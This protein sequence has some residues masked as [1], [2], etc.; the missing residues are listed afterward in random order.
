MA[1]HWLAGVHHDG[2]STYVS[3][4]YPHSGETVTITIRVPTSAPVS[5]V[6]CRVLEDGEFRHLDMQLRHTTG[7]VNLWSLD[8]L[9]QQPRVEYS[10]KLMTSE[11]AYYYS[12]MGLSRADHPTFFDF[13]ILADYDAPHWVRSAVFYQIFPDRFHNGDP[14]NDV[15][16]G[17]WEREGV[18]TRKL[19]WGELPIPWV[20]A[21]SVDFAGGDLQGIMQKLDYIASLGIGALYLTP[22]FT[23]ASNHHYDASTFNE[24]D[25]HLG[26][27][28][29][30]V[31]LRRALTERGM[32]LVLDITPNH[33]GVTHYWFT[34]A[35]A[36]PHGE[37][38]EYFVYNE[39]QK[40]FETWL[41]VSSLI[42]LNYNSQK[43]RDEMYR[44]PDSAIRRWLAAPYS[45]DGWRLDVANMVGNLRMS[46]LD[47]EVW[48][49]MRPYVKRDNP[50]AYLLGEYFQDGTP[51]TQGTELDAA[52]NY[53]GFNTPVRRWLGGADLGT[54]DDKVWGDTSLLP[55]DALAL[56][57]ERFQAAVPFVIALQQFNQVSSHDLNRILN[58]TKGNKALVRLA[59]SLLMAYIGVP[60]LYYGDEIGLDG[61]KDPDNRRCMPWDESEWDQELL[62]HHRQWIGLRNNSPAL[63][64]GGYQTLYAAGDTIAFLREAPQQ[65]VIFVGHRGARTSLNLPVWQAGIADGAVLRD[66]ASNLT[67]TVTE[68]SITLKDVAQ[69]QA[70]LFEV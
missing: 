23:A 14:S 29:A 60:C 56:Q 31:E 47:H 53:Q 19:Q 16:D 49:E 45:I 27:D 52:M 66:L 59:A 46:Q 44:R 39:R 33:V 28:S 68:G 50:E 32:R 43:L 7:V 4:P 5:S 34:Q 54:W 61:G 1:N 42:K 22:I 3:N 70:F 63:R 17:M 13:L 21:R 24:I 26:G 20:K 11:G 69:G 10:F 40:H 67:V 6:H 37:T 48:A 64:D 38:A 36:D 2:S 41:G 35:Q 30:L 62:A 55:T 12:S 58:I 25:P 15:Q 8:L 65:R 51:H 57:L 9:I 18:L